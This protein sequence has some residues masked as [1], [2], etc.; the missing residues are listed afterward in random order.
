MNA[1]SFRIMAALPGHEPVEL[2]R[3]RRTYSQQDWNFWTRG[4]D[5][6]W[7]CWV[8]NR[9]PDKWTL[10]RRVRIKHHKGSDKHAIHLSYEQKKN[11]GL[12]DSNC[13][14]GFTRA[15]TRQ[16]TTPIK[17]KVTPL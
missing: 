15:H 14:P 9:L 2:F 8:E 7:E 16:G 1:Y 3:S 6:A 13:L 4:M 12:C 10:T 5:W 11:I 17:L